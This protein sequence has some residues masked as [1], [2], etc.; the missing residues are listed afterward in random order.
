MAN[1]KSKEKAREIIYYFGEDNDK[2]HFHL[3]IKRALWEA[4]K[5]W[6]KENKKDCKKG[7]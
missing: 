1:K 4:V 2:A 7:G 6:I 3:Q 5:E